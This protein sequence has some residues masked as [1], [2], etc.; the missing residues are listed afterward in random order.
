MEHATGIFERQ[1]VDASTKEVVALDMPEHPYLLTLYRVLSDKSSDS[2]GGS[3]AQLPMERIYNHCLKAM[4]EHN[5]RELDKIRDQAIDTVPDVMSD[6]RKR[7]EK[8]LPHSAQ[9]RYEVIDA[10]VTLLGP[11]FVVPLAALA[12]RDPAFDKEQAVLADLLMVPNWNYSGIDSIYNFPRTLGFVFQ[13]LYGAKSIATG[14]PDSAFDLLMKMRLI[15]EGDSKPLNI[16]ERDDVMVSP[17]TIGGGPKEPWEYMKQAASRMEWLQ[18][19]FGSSARYHQ[20]LVA[21]NIALN[22]FELATL[23]ADD[24]VHFISNPQYNPY[25]PIPRMPPYFHL[26]RPAV[27]HPAINLL[28][29]DGQVLE[30]CWAYLG[31]SLDDM[32]KYWNPWMAKVQLYW[33]YSSPRMG[34]L[35]L[36]HK[37]ILP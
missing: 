15:L 37:Y 11:L 7:Y 36:P 18:R 17:S 19:V 21:Y 16:W 29:K 30:A 32:K 34:R 25:N 33:S 10:V 24:Q 2:P 13:S 1:Q 28:R 35:S 3:V 22:I 5:N 20:A 27:C 23:I 6:W 4:Q 26:E 8:D 9:E 12:S 14:R 31:V